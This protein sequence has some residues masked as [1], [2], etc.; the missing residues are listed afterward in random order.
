MNGHRLAVLDPAPKPI[1]SLSTLTIRWQHNPLCAPINF[2][3]SIDH[4]A[5]GHILG[6]T[7][8]VGPAHAPRHVDIG[9]RPNN[10]EMIAFPIIARCPRI[11]KGH[12]NIRQS[13]KIMHQAKPLLVAP[14]R[15]KQLLH[16]VIT[17]REHK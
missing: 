15:R 1:T 3:F 13:A 7:H 4:F 10:S 9:W 12:I 8:K 17:A 6:K 11:N 2:N 5:I 16:R 14:N